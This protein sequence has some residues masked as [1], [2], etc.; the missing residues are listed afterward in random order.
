MASNLQSESREMESQMK[1]WFSLGVSNQSKRKKFWFKVKQLLKSYFQIMKDRNYLL[2]L[3]S[4]ALIQGFF[5]T[6]LILFV[7]QVRPTLTE[8][9]NMNIG[10]IMLIVFVR[11][12]FNNF[13]SEKKNYKWSCKNF[14]NIFFYLCSK[15]IPILH[16]LTNWLVPKFSQNS[17]GF[18]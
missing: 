1:K 17:K 6:F 3:S 12:R 7:R 18:A 14:S 16:G 10:Y 9:V 13:I 4:W 11:N 8:N 2:L 15:H 5:Q